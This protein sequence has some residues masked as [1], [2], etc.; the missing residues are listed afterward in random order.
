MAGTAD[1]EAVDAVAEKFR[2]GDLVGARADCNCFFATV[3]DSLRQAPLRFWLG[4]IE[5]RSGALTA[6]V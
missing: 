6:A 1:Q 5:Q 2:H 4:A 3:S